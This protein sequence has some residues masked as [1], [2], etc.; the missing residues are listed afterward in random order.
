MNSLER[1]K[2]TLSGGTVDRLAVQPI[3]MTFAARWAGYKYGEY[4]KDYRILAESQLR[5]AEAFDFDIL[6]LCSDPAREA[7]DCGAPVAWFE[8]QPPSQRPEDVLLKEKV[9]L[10][11]LKQP[12]PLGGGRMHDRVK[13]CELLKQK[14]AGQV[15]VLGWVEGPLAQAADLRGINRI[16]YDLIDDPDWVIDLFNFVTEMEIAFAKAQAPFSDVIGV[17]DAACSLIS[18]DIYEEMVMPYE[19]KLIEAIQQMGLPVRLHIC[20]DTT[21]LFGSIG[22]L[23]PDIFEI[24]SPADISQARSAVGNKTVIMGNVSPVEHILEGTPESVYSAFE[25]CWRA[26]GKPF[27]VTPGCEI[28]P[29]APEENVRAMV[30]FARNTQF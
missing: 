11:K 15:P 27:I 22:K 10:L 2:A 26:T 24:D 12:D 3:S 17:G 8:D 13:G 4:C 5:L 1:M 7:A 9:D 30:E 6:N 19:R 18:A 14:S 25:A 21:H 23:N 29:D 16:M 20:G 28:P